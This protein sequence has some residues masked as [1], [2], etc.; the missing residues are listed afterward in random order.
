M[1]KFNLFVL[2]AALIAGFYG[3]S[4]K[5]SSIDLS[6]TMPSTATNPI[7]P[8]GTIDYTFS[9]LNNTVGTPAPQNTVQLTVNM[10]TNSGYILLSV[11]AGWTFTAPAQGSTAAIIVTNTTA[12]LTNGTSADF[13]LTTKIASSAAGTVSDAVSIA[14]TVASGNTDP[15]PGNNSA[16]SANSALVLAADMSVSIAGP[17]A[18]LPGGSRNMTVTYTCIGPSDAPAINYITI[19]ATN[20]ATFS[21]LVSTGGPAP[22]SSTVAGGIQV[23]YP[24]I[25]V[26]TVI[27]ITYTETIP[28]NAV[29]GSTV[30]DVVQNKTF[31]RPPDSNPANDTATSNATVVSSFPTL[32]INSPAVSEGDVGTVNVT[33]TV[34]LSAAFVQIVSVD[35]NTLNGTGIAPNDYY[36]LAGTVLFNPG[37]LTKPVTIQVVSNTLVEANK[38]FSVV[39]SNPVNA[40]IAQGTG[41]CTIQNDDF[42]GSLQFAAATYMVNANAGTANIT[43]TRTGGIASN[44]S[45]NYATSDGTAVSGQDYTG[46][47][48]V[49]TFNAGEV[50]KSFPITLLNKVG[51]LAS[52]TVNLT[53][54]NPN[55]GAV[56]VPGASATLGAQSTAIMT[57]LSAPSITSALSVSSQVGAQFIY[58]PTA[59]GLPVITFSLPNPAA[60]PAGLTFTAGF[61]TGIPTVVGSFAVPLRADNANGF[62][63]QTLVITITAPSVPPG[64]SNSALDSDSD[65]FPDELEIA[66]GSN[67]FDSNSTPLG[68]KNPQKQ[69][70]KNVKLSISLNF[71]VKASDSIKLSGTVILPVAFAQS[72]KLVY[73]DIGGVIRRFAL[74]ADGIS[75][76]GSDTV[77]FKLKKA[78]AGGVNALV[79][80]TLSI[81][82]AD[83]AALL[84][85]EGLT[86]GTFRKVPRVVPV[87]LLLNTTLY[88]AAQNQLYT[89]TAG[90]TGKTKN[91]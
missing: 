82:D 83:I 20:G 52:A 61:I 43:V 67:P 75:V 9:A 68:I 90:R 91:P 48:G 24:A 45:I 63:L 79:P 31:A 78:V 29:I 56:I 85:D 62:D 19:P 77:K 21:N 72:G 28:G 73:F 66:I 8:G 54:S 36:T 51:A 22:T 5:A 42:A 80:F 50:S 2:S 55:S 70:M 74:D 84:T 41:V 30:S 23:N 11:P 47:S 32:S 4:V 38:T 46:T 15:T 37:E 76:I 40:S 57:I 59:T 10:P 27:T 65:G 6:V 14:H 64:S 88:S 81:K 33:F 26:G 53:L 35:F 17:N 3:S 18:L 13:T 71:A 39:L 69:G 86:N 60:L 16:T 58:M 34:T 44:T 49:L 89:A 1:S 12:A 87:L 25:P 7:N